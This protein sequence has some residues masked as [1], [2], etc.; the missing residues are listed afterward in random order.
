MNR[1]EGFVREK[2]P[3]FRVLGEDAIGNVVGYGTENIALQGQLLFG[4]SVKGKCPIKSPRCI[5]SANHRG[6][7]PYE[8]C[9]GLMLEGIQVGEKVM[10]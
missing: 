2:V 6:E 3:A 1:G 5:I 4:F 9:R 7:R 10:L 8:N